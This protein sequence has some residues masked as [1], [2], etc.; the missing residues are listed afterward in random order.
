MGMINPRTGLY[1]PI[2]RVVTHDNKPAMSAENVIGWQLGSGDIV[3]AEQ[4]K[5]YN[6]ARIAIL[7]EHQL[8]L[9]A[10]NSEK[11]S[12]LSALHSNYT[13]VVAGVE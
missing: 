9:N 11:Q 7:K 8:K 2:K 12:K 10:I 6:D 3:Y 4:M 1:E 5:G 13:P